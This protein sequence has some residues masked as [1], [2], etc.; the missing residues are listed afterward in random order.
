MLDQ[1]FSGDNFRKILDYENRKGIH[2]EE[3]L[4]MSSVVKI[5]SQIKQ[6]N[7]EIKKNIRI[8]DKTVVQQLRTKRKNCV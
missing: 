5:N 2:L 1:S 7:I 8:G 3:K 6:C 4:S